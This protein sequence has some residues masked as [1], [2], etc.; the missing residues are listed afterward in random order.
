MG[1]NLKSIDSPTAGEVVERFLTA[2]AEGEFASARGYLANDG[3]K[4]RGPVGEFDDANRFIEDIGRVGTILK[5]VEVRRIFTDADEVLVIHD[6][7]STLSEL[8]RTRI[9][10]WFQVRDGSIACLEVFFDARAYAGLFVADEGQSG[11]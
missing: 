6:F 8:A 2:V 1:K 9:A 10:A 11:G 5:R 7:Y 3:F 4:Y